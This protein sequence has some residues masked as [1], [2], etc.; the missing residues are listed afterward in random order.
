VTAGAFDEIPEKDED[1]EQNQSDRLQS[2]R[3]RAPSIKGIRFIWKK[4][5]IKAPSA[6]F[7]I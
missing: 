3:R 7:S 5:P 2:L 1:C 6:P 4:V